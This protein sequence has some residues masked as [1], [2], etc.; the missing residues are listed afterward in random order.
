MLPPPWHLLK[1]IMAAQITPVH[2]C[3]RLQ[4]VCLIVTCSVLASTD[5]RMLS[6]SRI[7]MYTA[8]LARDH[9]G[10]R[11]WLACG[12]LRGCGASP[13]FEWAA[14]SCACSHGRKFLLSARTMMVLVP[15]L[16]SW[17]PCYLA[18]VALPAAALTKTLRSL[19]SAAPVF[20]CFPLFLQD[21]LM[22][23]SEVDQQ[24][25]VCTTH[26]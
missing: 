5:H 11:Q 6:V 23:C 3:S 16:M 19:H 15:Q 13:V 7:M 2:W 12:S 25:M 22:P 14:C 18:S 26:V 1:W 24:L 17:V 9:H 8:S 20:K 21:H 4:P 10:T